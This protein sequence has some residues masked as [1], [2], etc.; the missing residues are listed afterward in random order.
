MM[1]GDMLVVTA[2]L[3]VVKDAMDRATKPPCITMNYTHGRAHCLTSSSQ[4]TSH[5]PSSPFHRLRILYS[6]PPPPPSH[7]PSLSTPSSSITHTFPLPPLSL[8]SP[9]ITNSTIP[10]IPIPSPHKHLHTTITTQTFPFTLF[11]PTTT[12]ISIAS[13]LPTSLP[14]TP[15]PSLPSPSGHK[16]LG[17]RGR[18]T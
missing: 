7:K 17:T 13:P 10:F 14:T 15:P 12:M 9:S 16:Q 3:L 4:S 11:S 2:T 8:S 6:T 5:L 1:S 18:Q